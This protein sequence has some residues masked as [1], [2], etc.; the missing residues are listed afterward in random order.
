MDKDYRDHVDSG[1][2]GAIYSMP[3]IIGSS[4]SMYGTQA[5]AMASGSVSGLAGSV[6]AEST[7]PVAWLASGLALLAGGFSVAKTYEARKN[8]SEGEFGDA[9]ESVAND[10]YYNT[11]GIDRNNFTPEKFKEITGV[12]PSTLKSKPKTSEDLFY[13]LYSGEADIKDPYLKGEVDSQ[14]NYKRHG[15]DIL[16]NKNMALGTYD[17][18]EQAI[19]LVP[20]GKAVAT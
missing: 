9:F 18:A 13:S 2:S 15:A 11:L 7:G 5:A 12:D 19:M 20:F 8:E 6:A 1:D 17:L 14:I 3:R 16:Y 4:F 10:A